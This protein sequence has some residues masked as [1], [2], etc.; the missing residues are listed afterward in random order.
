MQRLEANRVIDGFMTLEKG[1]D[2]GRH[3]ALLEANQSAFAVNATFRG[4]FVSPRPGFKPVNVTL[5]SGRWQGAAYY[6]SETKPGFV[7]SVNGQ[8]H[9]VDPIG[10]TTSEITSSTDRNSSILQKTYF[11]QAEEYMIIQNGQDGALIW[12]GA[13][14]RRAASNE[15]P[16]GTVMAYGMGRLWVTLPGRRYFV[17]GNLVYGETATTADLLKFDENDFLNGGGYF[18]VPSSAGPITAMLFMPQTD[19][20]LGQGPLQVFTERSAFSVRA[21]IEREEWLNLEYPIQTISLMSYGALGNNSTIPVNGDVWYRARDGIRSFVL[22]S[23]QF[24]EWANTPMSKEMARVTKY[25]NQSL[26]DRSSA[27]LFDNRILVTALP[28][29][30]NGVGVAHKGIMVLDFDPLSS[31]STK[32]APAWDGLWCG[33]RVLQLV[34]GTFN[35]V[36][37]AYAF[38]RADDQS[39]QLWEI[40]KDERVD[41]TSREIVWFFETRDLGFNDPFNLKK[42]EYVELYRDRLMG[43]VSTDIKYRPD[44]H[45]CWIDLYEWQ[46]CATIDNCTGTASTCPTR[47]YYQPQYRVSQRT[48]QPSDDCDTVTGKPYRRGY[49]FQ[50]R[51]QFTG[52]CRVKAVRAHAFS[53]QEDNKG[54]C[55]IDS[56]CQPLE[57]CNETLIPSTATGQ[58]NVLADDLGGL[59]VTDLGDTILIE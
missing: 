22:A 15:V 17:G 18:G 32:L 19:T 30:I 49:T 36:E 9:F 58:E 53:M 55:I 25:D 35:G 54:G 45:P 51:F 12:N 24:G 20:S 27:I 34:K 31:I 6:D 2:S 50:L 21:P 52:Y 39:I 28:Y 56:A 43:T 10:R 16:C 23:R 57:C 29:T 38:V 59:I 11:Q 44:Q 13:S 37:R 41:N 14:T 48:P 3:P 40:T 5:T 42:L 47:T 33:L 46:E 8:V 7:F 4:G 26:L 1:V